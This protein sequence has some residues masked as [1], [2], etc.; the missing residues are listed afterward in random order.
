MLHLRTGA[1]GLL[2]FATALLAQNTGRISGTVQDGTGAAIPGAVVSLFMPGG[3]AAIMSTTTTN[4]GNYFLAGVQPVTYDLSIE[5]KGFRKEIYRAIKVDTGLELSM[6]ISKLEVSSQAEVVEV[7][8]QVT[9]V[10]TSNA[11]VAS[12]IT[13]EQV[14]RLPTLNRSPL[15]L[16]GSQAGVSYNGKTNTTIN[17]LRPS[18]ANVTIDGVNLQDNFIRTNTLDFQPNMLLLDQVGEFTVATSNTNA[19]A[20]SGAAQLSFVTPSG[21]NDYHGALYWYNRNNV[22]SA[23]SWFSNRNNVK[24]PFLNQN[25]A[26]GSFSGRIIKDKLFFYGNYELLRL[27]QQ[28]AT[29]RTLLTNDARNGILTYRDTGGAIQKFNVLTAAGFTAD[30]Q[31]KALL[32]KVP[33]ADAINRTDLGDGLNTAGYGFN[34]RNNRTRDNITG[35]G[36]YVFSTKHVFTGSYLWNRDIVD[37]TDL[38]NNFLAY[39]IVTNSGKVN[40]ASGTW[41]WSPKANMTN[42][43]RGGFNFA[44]ANFLTDETFGSGIIGLPLVSN[45]VNTFRA[46]GRYTDTY[47][48]Q[49]NA[50]WFIGK[51]TLSFGFQYQNVHADP[52]NDAGITATYNL[53]INGVNYAG[54][55]TT[56]IPGAR[57]ADVTTANSLLALHAGLISNATQTFNVTDRTS[58]FT[59]GATNFRQ[60]RQQNYSLYFSDTW[61]FNPR[62][63]LT[64][65]TRWE[66]YTPVDEVN[67]LFLLPQGN[68]YVTSLLSNSTLD[69]AGGAVNRPWYKNDYNN[70]SPNLGLAWQPFADNGKTV[71]RAGYSINYPNDEFIVGIR[72]SVNTNAGLQQNVAPINLRNTVAGGLPTIAPPAFKVPRTFSENYALDRSGAAFATVD[73]NLVTPYVQ[74][75]SLSVQREILKGV[76]E[77][78]YVGNRSTKQFR[79]FDLNQVMIN[80]PGGGTTFLDDFRRANANGLA[81]A[82]AGRGFNPAYNA[83]VSGSVPLTFFSSMTNGGRLGTDG[84]VTSYIQQQQV[85][86]LAQYYQVNNYAGPY[87]FVRN[88]FSNGTNVM[89]NYSNANYNAAQ[90]DYRR[91]FSKGFQI[92]ANYTYSK[93]MSDSA[94]D[95]QTRFEPFLDNGNSSIERSRTPFDLT[96]AFKV[97]GVWDLPIGKGRLVNVSNGFLNAIVGGWSV[98][99]LMTWTSGA[100]FSI[101]SNRGTLNRAGRSSG[102]NTA[103]S[104]LDKAGLDQVV[105]FRQTGNGPYFISA[106]AIGADNRGVN[107]DGSAPFSGQAFF[108]PTAGKLGT[109][110]R[111]MF[112][113]PNFWNTDL[114]IL[115]TVNI[116]EKQRVELKSEW[117]NM[118]NTP[119]FYIGDQDIN[120]TTFG[121]ITSTLSGRRIIQFGLYYRF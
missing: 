1:V 58:G 114:A 19:A 47:N 96:H 3:A 108:N 76:L 54:F 112:S 23:N 25:Q 40:L 44:P 86:E 73:P 51:H 75:W 2:L 82:A 31:V 99:G 4:D 26:G 109:L 30:P 84:N 8:A 110:Q 38:A 15:A 104:L 12:T 13:N 61:R 34:I 33:G 64:L 45:P 5:A 41:R 24:R 111:R 52:Y 120:S 121:R 103:V 94:G 117:F 11:E 100:P 65:G 72:N 101:N 48:L 59:P 50:N 113:G 119:S 90:V 66:Y 57:A 62:L 93:V 21:T 102:L 22:T 67:A 39:P 6:K 85:G 107:A 106:S 7:S 81:S 77:V 20:G 116:T 36:D 83:A 70:F 46:Q 105:A 68:N 9:S 55:N 27:R 92:Q 53:G 43:L 91:F 56:I 115:K 69:F 42:E 87:S 88:P 118:T 98:S 32:A 79:A 95:G 37:R 78:R 10:Q 49:D 35:K 74:Q 17:G 63:T 89:T 28:S 80:V 18:Y 14:R 97:N 71:I 29:T 16:I 60:M